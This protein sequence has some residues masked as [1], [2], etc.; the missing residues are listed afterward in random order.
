[1]IKV[2]KQQT[3]FRLHFYYRTTSLEVYLIKVELH[4]AQMNEILKESFNSEN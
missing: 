4:L 2:K 3:Q 1:M